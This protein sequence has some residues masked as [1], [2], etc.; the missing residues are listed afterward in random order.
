LEDFE[1]DTLLKERLD[2]VN[3]ENSTRLEV[4]HGSRLG[5]KNSDVFWSTVVI[6]SLA[7]YVADVRLVQSIVKF[8]G[9][10]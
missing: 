2:N 1:P 6:D 3:Y 7:L 9:V 10:Y 5:S 8:Y 4:Q